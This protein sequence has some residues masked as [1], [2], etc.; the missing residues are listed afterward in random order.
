VPV[1]GP[2]ISGERKN[3]DRD[4]QCPQ[5]NAQLTVLEQQTTDL[6]ILPQRPAQAHERE[7]RPTELRGVVHDEHSQR[8]PGRPHG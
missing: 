3:L 1:D 6:D 2:D 4:P 7:L 8:T 5:G